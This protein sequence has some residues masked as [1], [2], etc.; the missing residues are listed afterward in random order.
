MQN[1]NSSSVANLVAEG[2]VE[3]T[4]EGTKEAVNPNGDGKNTLDEVAVP[5][6]ETKAAE[7][8]SGG[9]DNLPAEKA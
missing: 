9:V 7:E 3:T 1:E 6:E 5:V 8:A 2:P 4:T